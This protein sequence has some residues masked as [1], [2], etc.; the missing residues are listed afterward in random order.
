MINH[1]ESNNRGLGKQYL[2]RALPLQSYGVG[3][4]YPRHGLQL[5]L[6]L[7]N[8]FHLITEHSPLKS[9]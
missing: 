7:I 5:R 9:R 3:G 4:V 8:D 6:V 2:Y 1:V